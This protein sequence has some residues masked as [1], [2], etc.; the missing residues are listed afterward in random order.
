MIWGSIN[1]ITLAPASSSYEILKADALWAKTRVQVSVPFHFWKAHI[2]VLHGSQ[3]DSQ[4]IRTGSFWRTAL[5][6]P[7]CQQPAEDLVRSG[8]KA[9]FYVNIVHIKSDTSSCVTT[10]NSSYREMN[11]T[12]LLSS[13]H[14]WSITVW[15]LCVC[16]CKH[17][18][19]VFWMWS[20]APSLCS[21]E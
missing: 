21:L 15:C 9:D 8:G 5:L 11:N 20:T 2:S 17:W 18:L 4:T 16:V 13:P 10:E 3:S 7:L 1:T 12:W 6:V 14:S 19:I